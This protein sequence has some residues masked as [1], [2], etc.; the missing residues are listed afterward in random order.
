MLTSLIADLRRL[1]NTARWS[2]QGWTSAWRGEKSI[3]QWT[4]VN[5][6]STALSFAVHLTPGERTLILA[7]GVLVLVVELIN[8]AIEETVDFISTNHDPRA[9][10]AKDCGSAAVMLT[11]LAWAVVWGVV[12]VG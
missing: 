9:G 7:L 1:G 8:T 11:A 6:V 4:V 5:G 2:W 3:R 10:R 12:L